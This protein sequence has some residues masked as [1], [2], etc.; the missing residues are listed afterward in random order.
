MPTCKRERKLAASHTSALES[1]AAIG[2]AVD[3]RRGVT[4][5]ERTGVAVSEG[6]TV[7][8]GVFVG[9]GDEIGTGVAVAVTDGKV[10]WMVAVSV[11]FTV[12]VDGGEAEARAAL[13]GVEERALV[14]ES[15]V[16]VS[17]SDAGITG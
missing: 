14:G 10:F 2:V 12:P 7:D 11:G 9:V 6:A 8:E 4:V 13:V 1:M 15:G 17:D 3:S 5:G 16:E